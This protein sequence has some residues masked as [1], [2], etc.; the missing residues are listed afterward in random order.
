MLMNFYFLFHEVKLCHVEKFGHPFYLYSC[1][2]T[3]YVLIDLLGLVRQV[4]K[5]YQLMTFLEVIQT[6]SLQTLWLNATTLAPQ[7]NCD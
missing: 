3:L 6:L 4:F 2:L 1:S 5:N 7:H